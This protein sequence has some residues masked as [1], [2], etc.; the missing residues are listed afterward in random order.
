MLTDLTKTRFIFSNFCHF[1]LVKKLILYFFFTNYQ[2]P[3]SPYSRILHYW[4]DSE[5]A[6][7]NGGSFYY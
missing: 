7:A 2:K 6:P 1:G 5:A 3:Y 4:I